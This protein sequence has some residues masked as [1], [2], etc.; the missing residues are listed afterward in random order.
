M[1]TNNP[2]GYESWKSQE[3]NLIAMAKEKIYLDLIR[4]SAGFTNNE[5]KLAY[6]IENDK[7]NSI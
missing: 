6:H 2:E 3:V 1:K 7:N 5:G 4:S